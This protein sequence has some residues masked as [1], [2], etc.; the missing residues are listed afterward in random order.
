M[1]VMAA[2]RPKKPHL[3]G[4][5][6]LRAFAAVCVF[7]SNMRHLVTMEGKLGVLDFHR[8]VESGIGV[9]FFFLLSGYL[10]TL[11]FWRQPQD[12]RPWRK[13]L[14]YAV[15][16]ASRLLPAYFACL[17]ALVVYTKHWQD[18]TEIERYDPARA[19]ATQFCRVHLLRY[20]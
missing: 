16:R 1:N 12:W 13:P 10:L 14:D 4:L 17:V 11:G 3:P 5:D 19:V 20:Q 8:F 7:L 2:N 15:R 9:L 6:G 18:P